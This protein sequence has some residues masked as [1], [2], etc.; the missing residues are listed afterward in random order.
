MFAY[1]GYVLSLPAPDKIDDVKLRLVQ[2][3]IKQRDKFDPAQRVEIF[4]RHLELSRRGLN[5]PDADG[6]HITHVIWPE[7][8]LAFLALRS[9]EVLAA[10]AD[11]LPDRVT[12]IAGTLRLQGELGADARRY[13]VFNSAMVVGGDGRVI[14]VY[15]KV[16]L[17]PFGEYLPFQEWLEAIGLEQLTRV[18]GGFS[19]GA[20][21]DAP[22]DIP[23]LNGARILI[24]YE[25]IFPREVA[26]RL[27][28]PSVLINLTNDAWYGR[29]TGPFQH[30]HQSVVRAV[31]QGLPMVRVGN[32]GI[33]G[34]AGPRGRVVS[35]LGLDAVGI[36]DARLPHPIAPTVYSQFGDWIFAIL[37]FF[38]LVLVSIVG[39]KVPFRYRM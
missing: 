13:K 38:L 35:R 22:V 26:T 17:V 1:G 3:S 39:L 7:A 36:I 11:A 29:S 9:P 5:E 14:D 6:V 8:A 27:S 20:I 2:P 31:E 10:I 33:S 18:Q 15:D 23:L 25:V 34:I 16:H 24:C 32:N 21:R 30:F 4:T 12:L 37:W 19:V 28:R